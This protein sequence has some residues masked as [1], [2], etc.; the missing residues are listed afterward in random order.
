MDQS[1]SRYAL[2]SM[3]LA[4]L[5][6]AEFYANIRGITTHLSP[7]LI[8][9]VMSVTVVGAIILGHLARREVRRSGFIRGG[10]GTGSTGMILG[11]LYLAAFLYGFLMLTMTP[12]STP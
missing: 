4:I 11:Y 5:A 1:F 10:Y 9:I 8:L 2:A 7:N 3:L 6:P 12:W